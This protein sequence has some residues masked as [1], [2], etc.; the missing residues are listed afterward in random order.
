MKKKHILVVSVSAGAGHVRAAQAIEEEVSQAYP[1]HSVTH[2]DLLDYVS[3][4]M[5][6]VIKELYGVIVKTLPEL[7][8]YIYQKSD[9]ATQIRRYTMLT[10]KLGQLNA[11]KFYQFLD[12]EQPDQV[13]C[14][15]SLP[16]QI[17][18]QS[19]ITEH[20]R[21][22]ISMVIT[23]YF[24]HS[25][26]LIEEVNKYFVATPK[27][28]W[29]MERCGVPKKH[30]H[31][32]GIPVSPVFYKKKDVSVLKKKYKIRKD[33]KVVLVLSGG[34]GLGQSNK[35]VQGLF[36]QV[37]GAPIHI[38]AIAGKNKRL[39]AALTK[40]KNDVPVKMNYTVVG[41]TDNMDEYMRIADVVISKPGGITT[42]ECLALGKPLIAVNPIPGQEERNAQYLLEVGGGHI[43]VNDLDIMYYTEQAIKKNSKHTVV[44]KRQT[45]KNILKKLLV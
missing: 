32:S 6:K 10:N 4:P 19:K 13:I 8:G 12:T 43:A 38:I 23:D 31:V 3:L 39:H 26:W 35:I 14:T 25:Y 28:K 22:P 30:I 7:W 41:W 15:H 44:R 20:R 33:E 24:F 37:F 40:L 1:K 34:Q 42:S 17:I 18:K 36:G 9:N 5:K 29:H 27:M 11:T 45:T 2:V 16:A 21:I